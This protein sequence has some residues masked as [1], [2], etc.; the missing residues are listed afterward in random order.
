MAPSGPMSL[1]FI[2]DLPA[3]KR[4]GTNAWI[5]PNSEKHNRNPMYTLDD[6]P[7]NTQRLWACAVKAWHSK[8]SIWSCPKVPDIRSSWTAKDFHLSIE[9]CNFLMSNA[10]VSQPPHV[11][12]CKED[13]F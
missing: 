2:D 13:K 3:D 6:R 5:Q 9:I 1:L 7:T 8:L 10:S 12:S 11:L 4:I